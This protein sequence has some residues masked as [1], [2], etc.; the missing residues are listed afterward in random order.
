MGIVP[1]ASGQNLYT[2]DLEARHCHGYSP[3]SVILLQ[4]VLQLNTYISCREL[5]GRRDR[6]N[7]N[8]EN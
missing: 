3:P 2:G 1:L 7:W 8:R 6:E 5:E 4:K